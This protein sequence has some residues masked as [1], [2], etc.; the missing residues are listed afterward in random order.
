MST[1][2][3][4]G[5]W[6]GRKPAG[7]THLRSREVLSPSGGI[8]RGKFPSRKN[9]RMVHH[10]GLLELDA[11]YLFEASPAIDGYREQP[12]Q[13]PYPD[14]DRVRRYTPDFEVRLI[15][16]RVVLIEVKPTAALASAETAHKLARIA[17]HMH[18]SGQPFVVLTE[19]VLR[20]E[21]R[22][23]NIRT[24]CHRAPRVLPSP[25][26]A[27]IALERCIAQLP[28][29]L[30]EA[31]R[32]FAQHDIDLYSLLMMGLLRCPLEKEPIGPATCI[33]STT[34]ANDGWFWLSEEHGL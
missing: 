24:I 14:G 28:T 6:N 21:P 33:T 13:I 3:W 17:D 7:D 8:M 19:Q 2:F 22:Q 20:R 29:T 4:A 26:L 1:Q 34:E 11:I 18:R 23:S 15:D 9:G 30:S 10:E 27:R 16:G 25:R 5:L 12:T 32:H 31:T